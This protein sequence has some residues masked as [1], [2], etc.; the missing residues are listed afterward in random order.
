M[1]Q[2]LACIRRGEKNQSDLIRFYRRFRENLLIACEEIV[3][4]RML[5]EMKRA[6]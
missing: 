5:R 3:C 1:F 6:R 2:K 4:R